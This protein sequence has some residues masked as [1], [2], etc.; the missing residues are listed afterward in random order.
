M[1]LLLNGAWFGRRGFYQATVD[2]VRYADRLG[3]LDLGRRLSFVLLSYDLARETTGIPVRQSFLPPLV[4]LDISDLRQITPRPGECRVEATGGAVEDRAYLSGVERIRE[5]IANGDI[6]QVNLTNRFDFELV[7]EP[8][9]LFFNFVQRQPVPYSFFLKGDDFYILSGSMELFLEKRGTLLRS[10]PIKGTG[11]TRSFLARSDKDKAENLMI[12]DMV[13]NDIGVV[14]DTGTVKV[15]ELFTITKYTTLYQMH[16]TVEGRT[17][18]DFSA[19]QQAAFPPAS[20][21]GAPKIK[22]VEI[23]NA[24]EEHPRSYYCGSAGFIHPNGDFTQSVLIRTAIG[25]GSALSYYAGCGIVWDS[26][27]EQ[28]L[29]ELYL[30]IKAFTLAGAGS[31]PANDAPG[32]AATSHAKRLCDMV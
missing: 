15:P 16:S 6:Y 20:V 9:T 26:V 23:I 21:T 31:Q 17:T 3:G 4:L 30:K 32:T 22:A 10:K 19:I 12:T 5:H 18:R 8:R 1:E 25:R 27:P 13:R 11:T 2:R 29:G 24:L 7:G 28:E 14:A